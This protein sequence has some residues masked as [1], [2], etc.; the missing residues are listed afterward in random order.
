MRGLL[1]LSIL[2]LLTTCRPDGGRQQPYSEK[3]ADRERAPLIHQ[4][5]RG[6]IRVVSEDLFSPPVASRVYAYCNIAAYR[7][8]TPSDRYQG[9][10]RY[11]FGDELLF[12]GFDYRWSIGQGILEP[13]LLL[14]Y[15]FTTA[16]RTDGIETP[17]TGGHWLHLRP[18][19]GFA[20]TSRF[21]P[22]GCFRRGTA[23]PPVGRDAADDDSAPAPHAFLRL[24]ASGKGEPLPAG[25]RLDD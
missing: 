7:L 10:Q 12:T 4:L 1:S 16:D 3:R 21:R 11:E 24:F 20:P 5:N 2:F 14:R 19:M 8:T 18:G 13:S 22:G 23:V 6:L 17:N 15:R 25:C 9:R